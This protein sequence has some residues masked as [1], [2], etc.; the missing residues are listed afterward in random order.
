MSTK[1][2]IL[3][4]L[5]EVVGHADQIDLDHLVDAMDTSWMHVSEDYTALLVNMVNTLNELS[6]H[7][8]GLLQRHWLLAEAL[9]LR[10]V[11]WAL[12]CDL[13]QAFAY[14]IVMIHNIFGEV[15]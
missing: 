13:H 6:E 9:P 7:R 1:V 14:V 4:E 12:T 3:E 5:L 2:F 10:N 8:D 15:Y 11:L